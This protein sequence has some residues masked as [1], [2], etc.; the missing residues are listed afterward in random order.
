[1]L[2]HQNIAGDLVIPNIYGVNT[3]RLQR[4][5][6][7]YDPGSLFGKMNPIVPAN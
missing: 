7:K 1:M 5:K 6:A 2:S 4:L 3:K